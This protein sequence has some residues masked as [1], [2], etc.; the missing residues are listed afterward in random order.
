MGV[1]LGYFGLFVGALSVLGS[2][3]PS[4]AMERTNKTISLFNVAGVVALFLFSVFYLGSLCL[5]CSGYYIFSI[6]SFV[7]FAFY[8]TD[9]DRPNFFRRYFNFSLKHAATYAV[10]L[11]AGAYGMYLFHEAK[12]E[13]VT[14]VANRVV[15]EYFNLPLVPLPSFISP[16]R[17]VSSTEKFEDAPI[18]IVEYGDFLC[19][20][21]LL[22]YQ[23]MSKLKKEF[24]GKINVAFQFFPLES[25]CNDVVDK[26]KHPGSCELSY[27]AAKNPAAFARIHDEI[28]D[29]FEAAKTP[30][31][32]S[33]L[34]KKYN[35]ESTAQDPAI[36]EMVHRIIQTG[37]E[38]EK[39]ADKY[40]FGIRSTPTMIINHR[41]VIGTLPYAQLRAIFQALLSR[42]DSGGSKKFMENW[43]E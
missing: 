5:L 33:A 9:S 16:Y 24:A 22:L 28:Y 4:P 20:D 1:P 31:W 14:G 21:C 34:A 10:I 43:I 36:K 11:M 7:V 19:S 18:Q 26:N 15:E 42:K 39:T 13:A 8:G 25:V 6:A 35:A 12:Q 38:Y 41:M 30:V 40:A 27:I 17:S 37:R 3:F 23:Q 2:V 29:N 32:R